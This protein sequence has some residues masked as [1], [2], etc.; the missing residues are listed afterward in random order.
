MRS[1]RKISRLPN[2]D[3]RSNGAYAITICT[4]NR[5]RIFGTIRE[6]VMHLNPYGRIA[7]IEWQKTPLLRSYVH[8]DEFIIMPNHIH[9]ILFFES[10]FSHKTEQLETRE[11]GKPQIK[12]LGTVIGAYKSAVSKEIGILRGER[13][14]TWQPKFFEH[15]IRNDLDLQHQR[16]YILNNPLKW[17]DDDLFT[18]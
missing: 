12:S 8:L 6:G 16:E 3:Y 15:I 17:A 13:T 18:S 11:F 10:N 14:Q 5:K 9:A 7:L 4:F 1:T 2:F